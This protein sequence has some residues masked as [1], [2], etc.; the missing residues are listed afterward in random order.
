[1][2]YIN[3]TPGEGGQSA[4]ADGMG[5]CCPFLSLIPAKQPDAWL[6]VYFESAQ[7]TSKTHLL[8]RASLLGSSVQS[9]MGLHDGR[10]QCP[11]QLVAGILQTWA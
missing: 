10:I 8:R 1:M 7:G 6:Y 11:G 4:A 3:M 9:S 2:P 5:K